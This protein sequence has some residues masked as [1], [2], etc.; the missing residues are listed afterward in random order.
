MAKA[1][2][3]QFEIAAVPVR[4]FGI[5]RRA[6]R[7]CVVLEP[8]HKARGRLDDQ[9]SALQ[10]QELPYLSGLNVETASGAHCC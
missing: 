6:P 9:A 2:E 8:D 3:Q 5:G 1:P 4:V 7:R 10:C